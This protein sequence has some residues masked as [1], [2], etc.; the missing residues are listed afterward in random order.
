[1]ADLR[2][3]AAGLGWSDAVTVGASGNLVVTDPDRSASDC[4]ADLRAA[5]VEARGVSPDIIA[6]DAAELAAAVAGNPFADRQANQTTIVF[7]GE[8]PSGDAFDNVKNRA[9]EELAVGPRSIYIHYPAGLSSS[10]LVVPAA[11]AGTA[12]NLNTV[13]KLEALMSS[14]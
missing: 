1:M 4:G 9:D 2:E 14:G 10:R 6:L 11:A 8:N 7:L 5:L 13:A 12:R 3:V